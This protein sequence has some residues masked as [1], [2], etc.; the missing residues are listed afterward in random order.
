M[1]PR[2]YSANQLV[3]IRDFDFDFG[4]ASRA[5]SMSPRLSYLD[6]KFELELAPLIQTAY[7]ERPDSF[8]VTPL[9]VLNSEPDQRQFAA[10][11]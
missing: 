8:K 1:S 7:Q 6:S 2:A 10:V 11:S 4:A 5:A 3:N 9:L